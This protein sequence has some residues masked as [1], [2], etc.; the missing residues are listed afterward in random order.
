MKKYSTEILS[1]IESIINKGPRELHAPFFT[2]YEKFFLNKC[3]STGVVSSIGNYVNI[4][5]K[6]ISRIT[7]SKFT[8]AVNSGT[9]ALHLALIAANL[10]KNEEVLMPAFN[11][12]AN[13]NAVS[14]LGGV[15]HFVDI[16]KES[17]GVDPIKL[18]RY[19][20]KI[21]KKKRRIF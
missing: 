1:I 18:E 6:K 15:P 7:K 14:Y 16:E 21:L 12:I 4:F 10:K 17:L 9:S 5:E 2:S 20:L 11:F 3:I 8:V 19:L 13:A